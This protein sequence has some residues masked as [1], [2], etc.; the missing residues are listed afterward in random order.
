MLARNRCG[1]GCYVV[2][3]PSQRHP[4]QQ[5]YVG[6]RFQWIG[7][8]SEPG[9]ERLGVRRHQRHGYFE[10]QL[11]RRA[12]FAITAVQPVTVSGLTMESGNNQTPWKAWHSPICWQ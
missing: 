8:G 2:R 10:Y 5:C 4:A 12:R 11:E 6:L 1:P 3:N 9:A 7:Y